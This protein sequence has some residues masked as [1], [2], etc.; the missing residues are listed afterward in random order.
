MS[1]GL[2]SRRLDSREEGTAISVS[3][4]HRKLSENILFSGPIT[5]KEKGTS[6]L[7]ASV[8]VIHLNPLA[9]LV[10]NTIKYYAE[11]VCSV[12][13]QCNRAHPLY[14]CCW[15]SADKTKYSCGSHCNP[16]PDCCV[17]LAVTILTPPCV[18]VQKQQSSSCSNDI[19]KRVNGFVLFSIVLVS[20]SAPT[21]LLD[22]KVVP[23]VW[24]YES[25]PLLPKSKNWRYFGWENFLPLANCL[26]TQRR[27]QPKRY[28]SLPPF[29]CFS[30]LP[31][32]SQVYSCCM[33]NW[34]RCTF[35]SRMNLYSTTY[36]I[37][38]LFG[39]DGI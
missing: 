34:L 6:K 33:F 12:C 15:T 35:G 31:C 22:R 5:H 23:G 10:K 19:C 25:G 9:P 32:L 16:D 29:L 11:C 13:L 26:P 39:C 21:L 2:D 20:C 1:G 24:Y 8:I 30:S 27:Q 18:S 7:L 36:F 17:S 4:L 37:S 28:L 38:I 14:L 3:F